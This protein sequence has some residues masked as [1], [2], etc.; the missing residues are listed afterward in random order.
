MLI[1]KFM[2]AASLC[3]LIRDFRRRRNRLSAQAIVPIRCRCPNKRSKSLR[4]IR[5]AS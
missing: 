4:L 2:G 3:A 5:A 1:R